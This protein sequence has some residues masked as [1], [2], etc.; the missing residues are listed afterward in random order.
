MKRFLALVLSLALVCSL[1]ACGESG[2]VELG[3]EEA[4]I[5]RIG[6]DESD[7]NSVFSPFFSE[8]KTDHDLVELTQIQLLQCDRSGKIVLHGIEGE[9]RSFGG[10]EYT[11]YGPANVDVTEQTDGTVLY[12]IALKEGLKFSDGTP[13]TIDDVLFSIYVLC[14][15]S[16]QGPNQLKNMPIRGIKDYQSGQI[17]LSALLVKLG[18]NNQDFS[19]VTEEQQNLFW[20]T[21]HHGLSAFAQSLIDSYQQMENANCKEGEEALIYTPKITAESFGWGELSEDATVQDLAMA[22]GDYFYWDFQKM[23]EFFTKESFLKLDTLPA[24]L[25]EV[26]FYSEEKLNT[27]K[28]EAASISG[29]K[30]TG[31]NT[32]QI[33]MDEPN[34]NAI[35]WLGSMNIAPLHYYGEVDLYDDQKGNFG[36]PKGDLS[37]IREKDEA[38]MGA[39]PYRFVEYSENRILYENNSYYYLGSPKIGR[40][41]VICQDGAG[42]IENGNIDFVY[43]EHTSGNAMA[44]EQ[45]AAGDQAYPGKDSSYS[46]IGINPKLVNIAGEPDSEASK[47]LRRAIATV[48]AVCRQRGLEEAEDYSSYCVMKAPITASSWI[49]PLLN[50][51]FTRD[52]NGDSIFSPDMTMEDRESAA[53]KAAA[54]YLEKAGYTVEG[55]KITAAPEG[56]PEEIEAVLWAEDTAPEMIAMQAAGEMLADM[57]LN[58]KV[59]SAVNMQL[60]DEEYVV[61]LDGESALWLGL[62]EDTALSSGWYDDRIQVPWCV[63]ADPSGHL[64]SIY[65]SDAENNGKDAGECASVFG[66]VD[67]VLDSLILEG[68]NT[69]NNEARK[70]SYLRCFDVIEDWGCEIPMYQNRDSWAYRR[71]KIKEES[72]PRD[73]TCFYSWIREIHKLELT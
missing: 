40:L 11:Y 35:Y 51:V 60:E 64:R 59:V 66:V 48:I 73:L 14:D 36:F 17:S 2:S 46:Y 47:Y 70:D 10:T 71:A 24:C 43:K 28:G 41:E 68:E 52:A 18:E 44:D 7:L 1:A 72:V 62:W 32:L 37:A 9:T 4:D 23:N 55:D 26:Y 29:I 8:L 67:P 22:M 30:K 54:G 69:V 15:P 13:L 42:S 65:F 20:D 33:I 19:A 45:I 38:P 31:E 39:G 12:D 5:V 63:A 53:I 57:G 56:A 21:V 6:M 3:D 49:E 50:P 16:Y 25:G 27:E 58:I 61:P 34:V